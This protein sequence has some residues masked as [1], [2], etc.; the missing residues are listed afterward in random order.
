MV[1]VTSHPAVAVGMHNAPRPAIRPHSTGRPSLTRHQRLIRKF[2]RT[3]EH[4]VADEERMNG[5]PLVPGVNRSAAEC[6]S[7]RGPT[8][9]WA[10]R[11]QTRRSLRPQHVFPVGVSQIPYLRRPIGA[12]AAG[13]RRRFATNSLSSLWPQWSGP[14]DVVYHVLARPLTDWRWIL[15]STRDPT[16]GGW[17]ERIVAM[18]AHVVSETGRTT[19]VR[20]RPRLPTERRRST[21]GYS[22]RGSVNG[23][24]SMG[25]YARVGGER[26]GSRLV[27]E[28]RLVARIG[29]LWWCPASTAPEKS[30]VVES[31]Q[32]ILITL[33]RM[34][35]IGLPRRWPRSR[36]RAN[37]RAT[38]HHAAG[39]RQGTVPSDTIR[40]RDRRPRTSSESRWSGCWIASET[41]VRQP[42]ENDLS[43]GATEKVPGH[44]K[45]LAFSKNQNAMC[46]PAMS[47]LCYKILI[48]A[49]VL[50]SRNCACINS[51]CEVA[52]VTQN[53]NRKYAGKEKGFTLY[54]SPMTRM[55][56]WRS[57]KNSIAEQLYLFLK[58]VLCQ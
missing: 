45:L 19:S 14:C 56:W 42:R 13:R 2:G 8:V 29:C 26:R 6:A 12:A 58:L 46:D 43:G 23:W 31:M 17:V 4:M 38:G 16:S 20:R 11:G 9:S 57:A 37:H 15:N 49:N 7:V 39:G 35:C 24:G 1:D 27:G 53:G 33:P 30:S 54:S 22:R 5:R 48:D 34:A 52:T 25:S 18:T 21:C 55:V 10:P 41:L 28:Q 40:R 47:R 36:P 51:S 3:V 32:L 50:N 44:G